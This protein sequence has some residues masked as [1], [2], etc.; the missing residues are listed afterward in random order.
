MSRAFPSRRDLTE[1]HTAGDARDHVT[2]RNARTVIQTAAGSGVAALVVEVFGLDL[3]TVAA[4]GLVALCSIGVTLAQTLTENLTGRTLPGLLGD[5]I[6]RRPGD[7]R[8]GL[9]D[10]T[11]TPWAR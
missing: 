8:H 6:H 10:P 1:D 11:D 5:G 2:R 4:G 3:S 9:G 7:P